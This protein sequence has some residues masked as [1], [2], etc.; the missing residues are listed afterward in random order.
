MGGGGPKN[1]TTKQKV[2]MPEWV[3]GPMKNALAQY[4]NLMPGMMQ[5][6]PWIYEGMQRQ[7]QAAR[8]IAPS[9]KDALM[10]TRTIADRA[11]PTGPQF[12]KYFEALSDPPK[13]PF[14]ATES[15]SYGDDVP[16]PKF[17]EVERYARSVAFVTKTRG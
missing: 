11:D 5:Y 4:G 16:I 9:L 17:P 6:H 2:E 1:T 7:G 3:E 10:G 8:S 14:P 15:L 13:I 12:K